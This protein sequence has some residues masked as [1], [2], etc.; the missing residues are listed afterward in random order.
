MLKVVWYL[1]NTLIEEK[2]IYVNILLFLKSAW[3]ATIC[4]N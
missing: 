4:I 3:R 2:P 1:H